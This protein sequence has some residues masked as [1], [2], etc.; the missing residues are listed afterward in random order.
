MRKLLDIVA[1]KGMTYIVPA[2]FLVLVV[3]YIEHVKAEPVPG[4][5]IIDHEQVGDFDTFLK[6]FKTWKLSRGEHG[7]T[8]G[9]Q[10]FM[11]R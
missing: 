10:G 1:D 3:N 11:G 8:S 9:N 2:L 5:L 6:E 4:Y 7:T